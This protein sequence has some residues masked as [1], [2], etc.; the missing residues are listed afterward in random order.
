[1]QP[2]ADLRLA[3]HGI[4]TPPAKQLLP[5]AINVNSMANAHCKAGFAVSAIV[6]V[7]SRRATNIVT[8]QHPAFRRAAR[9]RR[10]SNAYCRRTGVV[11]SAAVAPAPSSITREKLAKGLGSGVELLRAVRRLAVPLYSRERRWIA[12]A[13]TAAVILLALLSTLYAV[14]MSVVLRLFWNALSQKDP[15][16][17]SKLMTLYG[18]AVV[19]G[20]I[21][22]SMFD[23]AKG[24]LALMWRRALV[25]KLVG[26][27]LQGEGIVPYYRLATTSAID[28]CDQR[29]SEDVKGFTDRA[30]RFFCVFGVAIFDLAIF[31]V[32]LYKIYSPLFYGLIAYAV[33][34]TVF[35]SLYGRPLVGLNS[36]QLSR[37]ADYRSSLLRIRDSAESIAF[38][39]GEASE[40]K[41]VLDRF[42]AVF[43]N[44]IRLLGMT[45]NVS[46]LASS[47]RYWVQVV[48]SLIMGPAFFAGKVVLGAVSQTLFSFNHVLSSISM[49]VVEFVA[50]SEFGAGV[51]RLDQLSA[52]IDPTS[53]AARVASS[54]GTVGITTTYSEPEAPARLVLRD[55]CLQTPTSPRR[56]LVQRLNLE[57]EEGDRLLIVG[58]SGIGKTS[59]LRA[60]A[61]LWTSG[62]GS[63]TRPSASET[64]FLPQRPF[65]TLGSLRENVIYPLGGEAAAHISDSDVLSALSLVNLA[66]LAERMGGLDVSGAVL[67]WRLSLG[68]QQRLALARVLISNPKIVL[69]DESTSALDEANQQQMYEL[70]RSLG[71]TCVSIGNRSSLVKHHNKVLTL[72]ENGA[73]SLSPVS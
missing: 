6:S 22:I 36:A 55:F 17:F 21:V 39:S 2:M 26:E 27:Y 20:P 38:Y 54:D 71:V 13:W 60:I 31:S 23:W 57:V 41:Q 52:A 46:F 32:L 3:R 68:E 67:S 72:E 7:K 11:K 62:V 65:L 40:K 16:K 28:N 35:I 47:H 69:L 50:L 33:V 14:G 56:P 51:R 43:D 73:W 29:L 30:V 45:R 12:I 24:R 8:L 64:L 15:A 42:R 10:V 59:L 37:E 19:V 1:M 5:L 66:T 53:S 49:I 61:G 25:S 34:G 58:V 9:C 44:A 70:L 18:V 4:T 63:V 48:P